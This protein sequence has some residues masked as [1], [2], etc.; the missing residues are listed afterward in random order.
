MR[1]LRSE[2]KKIMRFRV[3]L[4]RLLL[5][6]YIILLVGLPFGI[7][8]GL[9]GWL[10][11]SVLGLLLFLILRL[12]G[13]S[14]LSKELGLRPLT[15]IEAPEIHTL[16][17]EYCRRLNLP[18]P[19][20]AVIDSPA[21][22]VAVLGFSWKRTTIAFTRGLLQRCG[23]ESLSSVCGWSMAYVWF[24]DH[25]LETWLSRILQLAE[26]WLDSRQEARRRDPYSVGLFLRRL[27][28]YPFVLFPL[29]LLQ[30]SRELGPWDRRAVRLTRDARSL[31]ELLRLMNAS[32]ERIPVEATFCTRHLFLVLPPAYDPLLSLFFVPEDLAARIT[33][34]EGL[35][36]TVGLR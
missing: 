12:G 28:L 13:T 14:S 36:D 21:L 20:I 17:E 18:K 7:L 24:G 33:D 30:S 15:V 29:W 27:L 2:V 22:N 26:P 10:A 11:G 5:L 34:L 4:Y 35:T 6:F 9:N 23:R 8:W 16:I 25:I 3:F 19:N 31:S 1:P 32:R